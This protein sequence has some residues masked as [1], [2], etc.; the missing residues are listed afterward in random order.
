MLSHT[1]I[2]VVSK[3]SPSLHTK[4]LCVFHIS[5]NVCCMLAEVPDLLESGAVSFHKNLQMIRKIVWSSS[6]E[7]HGHSLA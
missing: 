1:R 5:P 7:S 6:A 4:I 2:D 3:I